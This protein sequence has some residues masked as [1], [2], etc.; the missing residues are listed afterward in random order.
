MFERPPAAL[1]CDPDLVD[2]WIPVP[3]SQDA[4]VPLKAEDF[5]D[6]DA[7][8]R[9]RL[10]TSSG[11]GKAEFDA[12]GFQHEGQRYLA[13]DRADLDGLFA[14]TPSQPQDGKLPA[15]AVFLVKYRIDGERLEIA[16]PDMAYVIEEFEAKRFPAQEVDSSVYLVRGSE[17]KLRKMLTG[18]PALFEALDD[19]GAPLRLR[20]AKAMER[21]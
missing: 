14:A 6:V 13:L 3:G 2:R 11:G 19:T 5:A 10:S 21:P 16:L 4:A 1:S 7:Q 15:T 8:C 9:V 20:R 18:Q 17:K 12:L